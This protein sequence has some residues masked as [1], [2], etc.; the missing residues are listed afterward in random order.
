MANHLAIATVTEAF[1][2]RVERAVRTEFGDADAVAKRPEAS[3]GQTKPT[4]SVFLYRISPSA[5]LRN[6][7]LPTRDA[8]GRTVRR[9]TAALELN[10]L[11]SF[12][13]DEL[14]VV[15]QRMLGLAVSALHARPV[16]SRDEIEKAREDNPWLQDSGLA[17][18]AETVKFSLSSLPLDDLSKLWSVFF[19]VPYRL[20]AVYDAGVVLV[21][22]DEPVR[23]PIP[24]RAPGVD[25]ALIRRP[26]LESVD[27]GRPVTGDPAITLELTGR[28]L[29]ATTTFIAFDG[30]PGVPVSPE[31][32]TRILVPATVA[33]LLAAGVHGVQ[34]LHE[35]PL[36]DPPVPHR[37]VESNV[38]PFVLR[39]AITATVSG[40]DVEVN[41]VPSVR[42]GQRVRLLLDEVTDPPP[43]GQDLRS[44][45]LEPADDGTP[46]PWD[47]RT[48]DA[49]AVGAGEYLVR[50]QV[51]GAE[52]PTTVDDNGRPA[53]K[54]V[55]S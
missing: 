21:E 37:A 11:L 18:E 30:E 32:N 33:T 15:P 23:R 44:V 51:D 2:L 48:F 26:V 29:R 13:G 40:T 1:R 31:G 34:V 16:L 20:S 52:S 47:T 8:Q 36:G 43:P 3:D 55:L 10:Y 38:L 19:Q 9:P 22:A 53:P 5:A 25:A 7:D 49:S 6:A 50:V 4:V 42:P 24:V 28:N 39:P 41:L 17:A 46:G 45:T 12:T 14:E 27:G 54:V 35:V